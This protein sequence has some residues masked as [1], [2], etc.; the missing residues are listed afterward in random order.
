[1]EG[2]DI[3]PYYLLDEKRRSHKVE[4][5]HLARMTD[6]IRTNSAT[7]SRLRDIIVVNLKDVPVDP[8]IHESWKVAKSKYS[9]GSQYSW[10]A[11]FLKQRNLV[12][13]ISLEKGEYG[14]TLA[15]NSEC[16]K[17]IEEEGSYRVYRI[18][19]KGSSQ[20][21][22][23][24][25]SNL[26]MPLSIWNM[27]KQEE[28]MYIKELGYGDVFDLTWFC[29]KPILGLPCGHC[30]PCKSVIKEGMGW[31]IPIW[32]SILYW[33]LNPIICLVDSLRRRLK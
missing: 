16:S 15:I 30:H 18:D 8:A 12:A 19:P 1:M 25:F 5:A 9:L 17:R 28:G 23:D 27:I 4:L 31:R 22:M 33:P 24:L 10:I 20:V 14:A 21:G 29:H 7:K 32:G 11:S 3:Q 2:Y 6:L 26:A 13:E